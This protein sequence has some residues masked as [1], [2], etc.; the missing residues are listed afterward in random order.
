[1]NSPMKM[2]GWVQELYVYGIIVNKNFYMWEV[3][4]SEHPME[5]MVVWQVWMT[6]SNNL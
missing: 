5:M 6:F 1:M 4:D 3:I 2:L